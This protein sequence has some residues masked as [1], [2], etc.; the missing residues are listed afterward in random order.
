[1][2]DFRRK[3]ED[4]GPP[5]VDLP[6]HH[7]Q[8]EMNYHLC[9]PLVPGCRRGQSYWSFNLGAE[10]N[11]LNVTL[12][13]LESGPYTSTIDIEQ[14]GQPVPMLPRPRIR[15]RLYHDVEMAEVVGWDEHR[16]WLPLYNYP[17][18]KMYQSDEKL[19]LNRFLGEWLVYCRKLGIATNAFCEYSRITKK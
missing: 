7:A 15:V 12:K 14:Q 13:L 16:H 5:E 11:G 1:M 19:V 8:C 10:D 6:G 17:N 2:V 18:S 9:M 3:I 4:R